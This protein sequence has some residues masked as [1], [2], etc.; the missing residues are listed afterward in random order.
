MIPAWQSNVPQ[1]SDDQIRDGLTSVDDASP[2]SESLL[3][4]TAI[5]VIYPLLIAGGI[6]LLMWF[7]PAP[8]TAHKPARKKRK[9]VSQ[10]PRK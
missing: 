8:L 5:P 1:P 3:Q 2:A 10:R 7:V 9:R 4:F 6:G